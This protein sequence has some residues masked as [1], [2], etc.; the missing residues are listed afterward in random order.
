MAPTSNSRAHAAAGSVIQVGARIG[1]LLLGVVLMG[2]L[3]RR[4]GTAEYGRYAV[5]MLQMAGMLATTLAVV[6]ALA[7]QPLADLLRSPGIAPLLRIL[8]ADFALGTVAG[9]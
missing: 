7:A 4:L 9:I 1:M 5:S 6:I 8:S 2:Y 3:A